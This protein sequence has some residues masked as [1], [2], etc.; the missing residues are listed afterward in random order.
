M[1]VDRIIQSE[2][3]WCDLVGV[4]AALMHQCLHHGYTL[5]CHWQLMGTHPIW[6]S[7]VLLDFLLFGL[8]EGLLREIASITTQHRM[9]DLSPQQHYPCKCLGNVVGSQ[10]R[11]G[12]ADDPRSDIAPARRANSPWQVQQWYMAQTNKYNDTAHTVSLEIKIVSFMILT[13]GVDFTRVAVGQMGF[14]RFG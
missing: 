13:E 9:L 14:L 6:Q 8:L 4:A 10:L 2:I 7:G 11:G 12:D 5:S 1:W 3:G